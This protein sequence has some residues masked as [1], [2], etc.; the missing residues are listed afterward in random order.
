MG[1]KFPTANSG[2]HAKETR[3]EISHGK[4]FPDFPPQTPCCVV[5]EGGIGGR[6]GGDPLTPEGLSCLRTADPKNV[7]EGQVWCW[8]FGSVLQVKVLQFVCVDFFVADLCFRWV[9]PY[10]PGGGAG[11]GLWLVGGLLWFGQ[12]GPKCPTSPLGRCTTP[13]PCRWPP[14]LQNKETW[15]P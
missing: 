2:L 13:L 14:P 8:D 11:G 10:P 3:C 4:N 7:V 12:F 5:T 6:A 9:P 15:P 1:A